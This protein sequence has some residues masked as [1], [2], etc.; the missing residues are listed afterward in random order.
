MGFME[1]EGMALAVQFEVRLSYN[2][3]RMGVQPLWA[4]IGFSRVAETR[5]L[6]INCCETNAF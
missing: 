2:I 3:S 5:Q 1:V 4:P 6:W